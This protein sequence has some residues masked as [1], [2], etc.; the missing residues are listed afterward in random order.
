[1]GHNYVRIQE[2]GKDLFFIDSIVYKTNTGMF[3]L[4]KEYYN[5]VPLL[6]EQQ[7]DKNHYKGKLYTLING[8][9]G[10]MASVV[11]S[12]LKAKG[13]SVFIGEESGGTMEGN[14][15]LGYARLLLPNTKIRIEI[16]LTKTAH[17]VDFVKGRGVFPDYY[18]TPKIED[19][20]AGIDTELSFALDL[21]MS[22]KDMTFENGNVR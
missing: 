1:M 16:P 20:V 8:A 12:F 4:K 18:V 13:R 7:P 3:R 19:L 14:T 9:S 2:N 15:S 11:S 6:N 22:K 17:Y 10:S 21:I 5:Y